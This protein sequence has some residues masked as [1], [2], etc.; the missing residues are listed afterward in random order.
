MVGIL[1]FLEWLSIIILIVNICRGETVSK[2]TTVGRKI[3]LQIIYRHGKNMEL[4]HSEC[5]RRTSPSKIINDRSKCLRTNKS[6]LDQYLS[7]DIYW[8]D[9]IIENSAVIGL[10]LASK[11]FNTHIM[12]CIMLIVMFYSIVFSFIW[13]N[14]WYW[15]IRWGIIFWF[16][17]TNIKIS[18]PN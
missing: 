9:E 15:L 7:Y 11:A 5:A 2:V 16:W 8:S 6:V 13:S 4:S 10:Q 14:N 1:F 12:H 17:R 3:D 18:Y